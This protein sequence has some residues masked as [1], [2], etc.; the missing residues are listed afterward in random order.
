M[1]KPKRTNK[2]SFNTKVVKVT[3]ALTI[4]VDKRTNVLRKHTMRFGNSNLSLEEQTGV[5]VRLAYNLDLLLLSK[6]WTYFIIIVTVYALFG[7]D[8][9]LAMFPK[10]LDPF[11][12]FLLAFTLAV[13]IFEF[14]A[15]SFVSK[16]GYL[17]SF[18][19]Y[20]DLVSILS[21]FSD[22][23]FFWNEI[24]Y[25]MNDDDVD[26]VAGSSISL[27]NFQNA[28]QGSRSS[29]IIRVVRIVRL[30]R[31]AKLYGLTRP[32]EDEYEHKT[33]EPSKVGLKL[34]DQT[35]KR[36]IIMV[37]AMLLSVP[38]FDADFYLSYD[39]A[40]VV[41]FGLHQLHRFAQDLNITEDQFTLQINSF[42]RKHPNLIFIRICDIDS[43]C[44]RFNLVPGG[45]AVLSFNDGFTN[46]WKS[47]KLR[48]IARKTLFWNEDLKEWL[49]VNPESG[50]LPSVQLSTYTTL[51]AIEEAFRLSELSL[52]TVTGC[53]GPEHFSVDRGLNNK[54]CIS[55]AYF[56]AQRDAALEAWLNIGRTLFIA[57][58]LILGN[59]F[60]KADA[61]EI[62]I[63]PIQRMVAK[64]QRF[65]ENP[66]ASLQPK[67]EFKSVDN[68]DE[69]TLLESS[70][71]KVGKLLQIGFGA[72]GARII[73]KNM[74]QAA[75]GKEIDPLIDGQRITA[76][77]GFC[78]L[79][80]FTDT[81]ECLQEKVMVYVNRVGQIVHNA[82]HL[83]G[84]AANK[85][86]GDAFLLVWRFGMSSRKS[87][88][89]QLCDNALLAFIKVLIDLK[90]ENGPDGVFNTYKNHPAI[91]NRFGDDFQICLGMGLHVG[92]AIEGAIGSNYKI[93]ASYLSPNVNLAARLEA[94]TKQ[95]KCNLLFSGEFHQLLS[96]EA[97][98]MCRLI[99]VVTVKGSLKPM[100]LYTFDI[101][102][103]PALFCESEGSLA[104]FRDDCVKDLQ[105]DEVPIFRLNFEKAVQ[106]YIEGDWLLA[107]EHLEE[108]RKHKA[109]DGPAESLFEVLQ[110]RNFEAP[111]EWPG[112]RV[113]NEK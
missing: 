81:T 24:I 82:T 58:V 65:A 50:K 87:M 77:F 67:H 35:M 15:A 40:D 53:Y 78:D 91:V 26:A 11:F 100:Q 103:Y 97:R 107:K 55:S 42:T 75:S 111:T 74:Q 92:W 38:F 14:S 90:R 16:T 76:I 104:D 1:T 32:T 49:Q 36:V 29:K 59:M 31:I 71:T 5:L 45:P 85:N 51:D 6:Q 48:E 30:V 89:F 63:E 37:L 96:Y 73:A 61:D 109:G 102:N 56:N 22:I 43:G 28:L 34:A 8:I 17:G 79:R 18:Y 64:M 60:H 108:A 83:F 52:S 105:K 47:S 72:A 112:Y 93:D 23:T 88:D 68:E 86:I 4:D 10:S 84:G 98:Q 70:L 62:V 57:L 95:F 27:E 44:R 41:E 9:R 54:P 20:L 69:T 110:N 39:K 46:V 12:D 94:A 33:M 13:F 80:Q 106:Q 19:F 66:M 7:D 101:I 21:M 99:D 2:F 3:P 113:L 25:L